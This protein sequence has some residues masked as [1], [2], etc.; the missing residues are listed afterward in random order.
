MSSLPLG[1]LGIIFL[2]V[3]GCATN[4]SASESDSRL[5]DVQK[6]RQQLAVRQ[7]GRI[8]YIGNAGPACF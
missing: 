6:E 5:W 2:L 4:P 3:L 1:L 7:A 8:G